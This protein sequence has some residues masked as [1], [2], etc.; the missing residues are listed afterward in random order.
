MKRL[1]IVS[2]ILLGCLLAEPAMAGRKAVIVLDRTGSMSAAESGLQAT[3]NSRCK[4]AWL[5]AQVK[6]DAFFFA[7]PTGAEA[8]L[9]QFGTFFG[10][11]TTVTNDMFG[12]DFVG[13]AQANAALASLDPDATGDCAGF[14]ANSTPLAD[15]I[16]SARKLFPAGGLPGDRQMFF[17]GDGGENFSTGPCSGA[18]N[19]AV[20]PP[21]D[22]KSFW[23]GK[24][25]NHLAVDLPLPTFSV[26]FWEGAFPRGTGNQSGADTVSGVGPQQTFA[27]ND[28]AYFTFLAEETGGVFTRHLA[29]NPDP[30]DRVPAVSTWGMLILT[31]LL[32]VGAKA[33]F[34]RRNAIQI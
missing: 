29:S 7:N 17:L 28:N 15:A 9:V 10:G 13:Q 20:V 11:V 19:P 3:G 34:N 16:C 24:V 8:A 26:D 21:F 22:D 6:L 33:Y 18:S 31:L 1:M 27:P 2:G 30:V 14:S 23:Q 4:D 5:L 12:S 25:L 32:L